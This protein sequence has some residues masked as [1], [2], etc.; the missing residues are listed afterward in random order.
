MNFIYNIYS[1]LIVYLVSFFFE[2]FLIFLKIME[3]LN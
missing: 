2:F 3:L 1:N